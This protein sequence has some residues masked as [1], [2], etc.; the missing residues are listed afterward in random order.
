MH[1]HQSLKI[2]MLNRLFCTKNVYW[3]EFVCACIRIP[4]QWLAKANLAVKDIPKIFVKG[5]SVPMYWK[6]VLEIWC[7]VNYKK[8]SRCS[9]DAVLFC[10]SAVGSDMVFH[11][12]YML[13][14]QQKHDVYTIKDFTTKSIKVKWEAICL[15]K[16]MAQAWPDD[17]YGSGLGFCMM[18]QPISVSHSVSH[19]SNAI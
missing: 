8:P 12:K 15:Y 7:K 13:E 5:K 9:P 4:I 14:L 16:A 17:V 19:S 18:S 2:Q 6:Q 1:H 10:N 11:E 3:Q